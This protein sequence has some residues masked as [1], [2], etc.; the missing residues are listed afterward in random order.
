MVRTAIFLLILYNLGSCSPDD[1]VY[2]VNPAGRPPEK[3]LKAY[4]EENNLLQSFEYDSNRL[5]QQRTYYE[6]GESSFRF[7]YNKSGRLDSAW[8]RQPVFPRNLY[9]H[10]KDSLITA[11]E[12]WN[13]GR[14]RQWVLFDRDDRGRIIRMSRISLASGLLLD[15]HYEWEGGN[16]LRYESTDYRGMEVF[17]YVYELKYDHFRNPYRYVFRSTGYNF[18]DYLPLTEN[19]WLE[20]VLYRKDDPIGT[21]MTYSNIF[22]YGGNYPFVKETTWKEKNIRQGIYAEYK[23]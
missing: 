3:F 15:V 6:R 20:L 12:V 11:F 21:R 19:N 4:Y 9:F 7:F 14:I 23:Y 13:G 8:V 18:V 1:P 10:Y 16:I 17:T 2:P 5:M 22:G